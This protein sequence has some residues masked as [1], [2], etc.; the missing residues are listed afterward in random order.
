M[1]TKLE[2]A[3]AVQPAEIQASEVAGKQVSP[4]RRER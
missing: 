4:Q 3:G 2:A 1:F